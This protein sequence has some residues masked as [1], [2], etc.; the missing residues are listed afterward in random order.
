MSI[1]FS[2]FILQLYVIFTRKKQRYISY[3]NHYHDRVL[4]VVRPWSPCN[5]PAP[6]PTPIILSSGINC[7]T[8][9][10]IYITK[11]YII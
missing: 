3:Y 10:Y 5:Y 8:R 4:I 2:V 6:S 1:C 7:V 11:L 9:P